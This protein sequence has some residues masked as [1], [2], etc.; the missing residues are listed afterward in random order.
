MVLLC[1]PKQF[2]KLVGISMKTIKYDNNS[3]MRNR[4]KKTSQ[5]L[6]QSPIL[7]GEHYCI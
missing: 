6:T 1:L 5:V 2:S 3:S 7:M 4:R